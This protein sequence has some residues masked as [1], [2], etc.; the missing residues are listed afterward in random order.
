MTNP[1][2]SGKSCSR[3][4]AISSARFRFGRLAARKLKAPVCWMLLFAVWLPLAGCGG[5]LLD[6][7]RRS[8]NHSGALNDCVKTEG[9]TCELPGVPF[10]AVGYRCVHTTA[11]LR[12]VYIVTLTVTKEDDP[13]F[14]AMATTVNLGLQEFLD[15]QAT[16]ANIEA[17]PRVA[18]YQPFWNE[19]T[20]LP[21]WAVTGFAAGSTTAADLAASKEAILV[22]NVVRPQ[23][24]IQAGTVLYYNVKKP[25]S[26][27]TN[28]EIDLKDSGTI[29][30]AT[31][32][33]E[34]T[35]LQTLASVF[36]P[37][38]IVSTAATLAPNES[39]V[40]QQPPKK[41]RKATPGPYHLQ[42]RIVERGYE[43]TFSAAATKPKAQALPCVPESGYVGETSSETT[44][45]TTVVELPSQPPAASPKP[46]K[47]ASPPKSPSPSS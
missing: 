41:P 23:K 21:G 40:T 33:Q 15:D 34:N 47:K 36:A 14:P 46:N 25:W 18:N 39:K 6:V 8:G 45:D 30:K 42:L 9:S 37:N 28:A 35:T 32:Q 10:Y 26:G 38:G 5:P 1:F 13:N 31:G 11:W 22:S 24:Y 29:G 2:L 4:P 7:S 27:T 3:T 20:D 19:F 43:Y 17:N 12:P 44:Y 16:F